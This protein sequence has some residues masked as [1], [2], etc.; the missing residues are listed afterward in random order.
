LPEKF[1]TTQLLQE[2]MLK[3]V[4]YVPGNSFYYDY[5]GANTMRINFSFP[6]KE[7][8]E[9]GIEILGNLIKSKL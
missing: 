4:A 2:A 8:I 5:S 9:K 6:S 3:G 7:E 1:N